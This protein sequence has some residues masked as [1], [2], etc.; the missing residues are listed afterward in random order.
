MA[1]LPSFPNYYTLWEQNCWR[2][3]LKSIERKIG[4]LFYEMSPTAWMFHENF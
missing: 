1:L 3:L 4:Q 2:P